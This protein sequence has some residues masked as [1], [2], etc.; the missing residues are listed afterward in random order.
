MARRE[1]DLRDLGRLHGVALG[2]VHLVSRYVAAVCHWLSWLLTFH[3]VTFAWISPAPGTLHPRSVSSLRCSPAHRAP[4]APTSNATPSSSSCLWS[5]RYAPARPSRPPSGRRPA[6]QSAVS[7]V[8]NRVLLDACHRHQ[9]GQF[10]QLH[11]FRFLGPSYR[12]CQR[13]TATSF[14]KMS[15]QT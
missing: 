9:P 6:R 7:L 13:A 2:F 5:S 4:S 10:G 1:L 12:K 11:L 14:V 3:F 8:G 15:F